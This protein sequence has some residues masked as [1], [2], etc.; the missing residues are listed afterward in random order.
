MFL[1]SVRTLD[2]IKTLHYDLLRLRFESTIYSVS[3]VNRWRLKWFGKAWF[4][5]KS[6]CVWGSMTQGMSEARLLLW[7]CHVKPAVQSGIVHY[8]RF[9]IQLW[10]LGRR[11]LKNIWTLF[12]K[13]KQIH[14]CVNIARNHSYM[15]RRMQ[16]FTCNWFY[17]GLILYT[18]VLPVHVEW[19]WPIGFMTFFR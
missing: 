4:I 1:P 19:M 16:Q 18:E 2:F 9:W 6:E 5:V 15:N 14:F 7:H 12:M 11:R 13:P 8:G 3:L 10:K 17:E